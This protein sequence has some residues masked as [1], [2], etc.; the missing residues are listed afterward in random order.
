MSTTSEMKKCPFCAEEIKVE[1][2]KCRHCGELLEKVKVQEVEKQLS[3]DPE[4]QKAEEETK[5]GIKIGYAI[6]AIVVNF[7][8]MAFIK[9]GDDYY[10][11]K[12]YNFGV[13]VLCI[14][15]S[16]IGGLIGDLFRKIFSPDLIMGSTEGLVKAK[17]FWTIGPQTIGMFIPPIIAAILISQ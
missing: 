7:L 2:I 5:K 15:F 1:A 16:Y 3:F 4:T 6:L 8:F 12:S 9:S 13:T 17:I 11:V 10:L 14:P